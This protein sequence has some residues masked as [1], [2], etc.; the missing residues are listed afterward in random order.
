MKATGLP[1]RDE[2]VYLFALPAR[3]DATIG[4]I[5]R[6]ISRRTVLHRHLERDRLHGVL[7]VIRDCHTV[8]GGIAERQISERDRAMITR[9]H[10]PQPGSG[11]ILLQSRVA[12]ILA[13]SGLVVMQG[14]AEPAHRNDD[15]QRTQ[16]PDGEDAIHHLPF[17]VLGM[18]RASP[19][20]PPGCPFF[21]RGLYRRRRRIA[22]QSI[23][24]LLLLRRKRIMTRLFYRL[25]VPRRA[26]S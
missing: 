21:R 13:M 3:G 14:A 23:T 12:E 16:A 17:A 6:V 20:L 1:R 25:C 11:T 22:Q 7:S 8:E 10:L 24:P 9:R 15:C 19:P 4:R 26:L 5:R 2:H 18:S